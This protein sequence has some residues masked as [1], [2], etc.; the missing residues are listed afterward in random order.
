MLKTS[1]DIIKKLIEFKRLIENN[2]DD[3]IFNILKDN[4]HLFIEVV[5]AL[6]Q[7]AVI[8]KKEELFL[9]IENLNDHSSIKVFLRNI[10]EYREDLLEDTMLNIQI[11]EVL[12]KNSL[13]DKIQE[14]FKDIDDLPVD[15]TRNLALLSP[16]SIINSCIEKVSRFVYQILEPRKKDVIR[17]L[18]EKNITDGKINDVITIPEDI[19]AL[20]TSLTVNFF[21]EKLLQLSS[22]TNFVSNLANKQMWEAQMLR[23][24]KNKVPFSIAFIDLNNMKALNAWLTHGTVDEV[25]KKFWNLLNNRFK[26]ENLYNEQKYKDLVVHRSGDEFWIIL[27]AGNN[28]DYTALVRSIQNELL[29][30]EK[31]PIAI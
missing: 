26:R 22:F 27:P 15:S 29:T 30:I 1:L 9:N 28:C 19:K 11:I 8:G 2:S 24:I 18:Q 6:K 4:Y 5:Q 31:T 10:Y 21:N 12:K 3:T 23:L 25:L 16:T 20:I 13:Y 17:E 14:L 7:D